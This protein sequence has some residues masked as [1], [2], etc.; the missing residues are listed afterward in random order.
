MSS[1]IRLGRRELPLRRHPID[2]SAAMAVC[3]AN[4]LRLR[5]LLPDSG[6][7]QTRAIG[8]AGKSGVPLAQVELSVV[9]QSRYTSTVRLYLSDCRGGMTHPYYQPPLL[10]VRLYHD[11]ATAEVISYQGRAIS[12][13][14]TVLGASAAFNPDEKEQVNQFLAECL[15]LCLE[16]GLGEHPA[17]PRQAAPDL[18]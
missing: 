4:Y 11:A 8:L 10:L 13:F 9:E 5:K 7:G 14:V 17:P 16:C 12:G 3:D 6:L 2:L 15:Q 1:S 18:V